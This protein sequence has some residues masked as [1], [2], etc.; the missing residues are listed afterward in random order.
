MHV[1]TLVG[2]GDVVTDFWMIIAAF[3]VFL[4]QAGFLLIE[5][6]SVRAKNSVNVAQKN[7][8]DLLLCTLA[9]AVV[10]FSIM[11]GVSV[12]GLFG[13]GGVRTALQDAGGW[14]TLLIFNLAFC[15]VCA[16][17]VSGAVAERM[18]IE[19]Y[20]ISTVAIALLVYPI[21][22]HWVWGNAVIESNSAVLA[23]LGF[24][25][26]AG[27]IAVHAL[28]GAFAL[29]AVI[30][31]GPREGRFDAEGRPQPISGFSPVLAL[32]GALIL[33][34]TWVPFNTGALE[35]GSEAFANAA[36]AT[37]LAGGMGGFSG[38]VYGYTTQQQ[39]FD[40]QASFNGMLGGL[41][42]VTTGVTYL[43]PL[44]A[45]LVGGLGGL[46]AVA[47]QSLLL[48]RFKLDD[49]VGV[50]AVHGMAGVAGGVFFP[51]VANTGL[52][53]G[54]AFTQFAVQGVGALACVLWAGLCS[55]IVFAVLKRAGLLRVSAAQEHLGLNFGEHTP[56]MNDAVLERTY[57][58]SRKA[59]ESMGAQT[60]ADPAR[61]GLDEV[62]LAV[63]QILA[64]NERQ[65]ENIERGRT[66]FGHAVE[67]ITDGV[68]IYSRH[69]VVTQ[70]NSAFKTIVGHIGARVEIGMSRRDFI[71]E[72]AECGAFDL[73]ADDIE[74]WLDA[75]LADNPL[76]GEQ[77]ETI[78][79]D[80]GSH[81]LRR[82]T[83]IRGGGQVIVMTDITEVRNAQ[84]RAESAERAKSE[85]LANMSHEI[86]TPMNGIIGMTELLAMT[87]LSPRQTEFVDTIAR[88]GQALITIINDILDFSKIEAGRVALD[89]APFV[90][91]EA[92]EDVTS[93]LAN[94]A[95][96]KGL[97]LLV[98]I[99][100]GLP[101]TVIGDV[102]RIRQILTNLVG[103]ALKFTHAGH[104]L[105][106]IGGTVDEG[107]ARLAIRVEDTGIGIPEEKRHLIFDKFN[108]A[109]GTNTREYEGTGLGL[110]I[111]MELAQLMEGDLHVD[112][113]VG[114]GSTFTLS[115]TLPVHAGIDTAVRAPVELIG[116]NILVVD[117]NE[118]NRNILREQIRHWQ[119]RSVCVD[120]VEKASAVLQG[121]RERGVRFDLVLTDF[122]MPELS[123]E[124]LIER[125]R[126]DPRTQSLP[127]I[128][129]SSA[130]D[131]GLRRRLLDKGA[132]TVLSKPARASRL[133]DAISGAI[134][135]SRGQGRDG[136]GAVKA[137][138]PQRRATDGLPLMDE[139][140]AT[141]AAPATRSDGGFDVLVAEDNETNR[142]YIDYVLSGLGLTYKIVENGRRAV[143]QWKA[144]AP[145]A[146]LMDV[147][148]PVMN[149]YEATQAI[150]ALEGERGLRRTPIIAVTAH[151]LDGDRERCLAAGMDD[152]LG[153]PVSIERLRAKLEAFGLMAGTETRTG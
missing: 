80:N 69:A 109:D 85:F 37:I 114:E 98:R 97:D 28:G 103:N 10:G 47:G 11:Y 50:V 74:D 68:L 4:M 73:G 38:Q 130:G 72:L 90:L 57:A 21:F 22:G 119:G 16:T 78:S 6:G 128:V 46:V 111:A 117:D 18:R 101:D 125:L 39:T 94:G 15:S 65:A 33:F 32:M 77:G 129:L 60:L 82:S 27:G 3:M 134:L 147:S 115:L 41:V 70:L 112:S 153:K 88:S 149:G 2:R 63:Q 139:R 49:P 40:P 116:A 142:L 87:E 127:V 144:H 12:S 51:F 124:D 81:Y 23:N 136:T 108:Q 42:A 84:I 62:G 75:Y 24:V 106:D 9:Y 120:S 76:D 30:M 135:E 56:G 43:G 79:L 31:L 137:V 132:R 118:I 138:N 143:D 104:V 61:S 110:A 89:P 5:A 102:G 150:R 36:L 8:S 93:L 107:M 13:T 100:P 20:L 25:D 145:K 7:V 29:V 66:V 35:P 54:N 122:Q 140:G 133:W 53:A 141:P 14:P 121:A 152:Y 91:R 45:V 86:R 146:V 95:A 148:M 113:A 99:D 26:H 126:L 67:S 19:G 64:D 1:A 105:I 52:P 58:A 48:H 44:G 83:P 151:T 59:M 131:D 17:I 34:V 123:G 96:E 55:A 92:V 71:R